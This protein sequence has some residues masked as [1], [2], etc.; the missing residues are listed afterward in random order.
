MVEFVHV[1]HSIA[2]VV[3]LAIH[4]PA[5]IIFH[6]ADFKFDYTPVD[7]KATDFRKLAELGDKE[8][9]A[10]LSDSTNVEKTGYTPSEKELGKTFYSDWTTTKNQIREILGKHLYERMKRRPMILPIIMEV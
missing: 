10:I 8:V 7:G 5:G 4:T 3:A 9:L 1:N 2:D 6:T